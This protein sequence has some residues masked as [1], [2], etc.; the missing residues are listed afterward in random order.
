MSAT[1]DRPRRATVAL[2]TSLLVCAMVIVGCAAAAVRLERGGATQVQGPAAGQ[3]GCPGAVQSRGLVTRSVARGGERRE[4]LVYVPERL[5]PGRA[6]PA[7]INLHGSGSTPQQ[8][9]AISGMAAAAEARGFVVIL[10]VAV[11]PFPAGGF[12]WNVPADPRA[13]DDVQYVIDVLDDAART[14]CLDASRIYATGFSG[15]ARLASALACAHAERIAALAAVGGLRAPSGECR[16][17]I[18][19]LAIHGTGDPINPYAGGGP[20]YWDHGVEAAFA[21]W[22]AHNG[23][24]ADPA[25]TRIAPAVERLRHGIC[26]AGTEVTLYRLDGAGHVWPGSEF[27]FPVERFGPAAKTFDATAAMLDFFARHHR[28]AAPHS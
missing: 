25:G 7:V 27:A 15:G 12:T 1:T 21:A 16:R 2:A 6:A 28:E 23:C 19:V 5:D 20:R 26:A 22:S 10:P 24:A 17:P 11:V 13:A 4:Y 14:W 8:Q 9:L 18:A 3:P